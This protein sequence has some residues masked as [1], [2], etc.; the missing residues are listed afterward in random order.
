MKDFLKFFILTLSI[1]PFIVQAITFKCLYAEGVGSSFFYS[2]ER[3]ITID[4]QKKTVN[5]GLG[6]K[7]YFEGSGSIAW[8]ETVYLGDGFDN[9]V[10]GLNNFSR[11]TAELVV[12]QYRNEVTEQNFA[13]QITY[14]CEKTELLF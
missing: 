8:R 5:H 7:E 12:R 2:A 11:V 10:I 6:P 13:G 3:Y 9:K 14:A 4:P 1:W